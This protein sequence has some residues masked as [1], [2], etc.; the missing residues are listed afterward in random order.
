MCLL[1]RSG[2]GVH[3]QIDALSTHEL[4]SLLVARVRL[5]GSCGLHMQ[6]QIHKI[7]EFAAQALQREI[8]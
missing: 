8:P 2:K 5:I 4:V 7:A 3:C 1:H 6:N